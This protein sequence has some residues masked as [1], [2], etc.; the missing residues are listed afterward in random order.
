MN[1]VTMNGEIIYLKKRERKTNRGTVC[2]CVFVCVCFVC[3][4]MK[5]FLL[6]DVHG[7]M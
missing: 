4:L 5:K 6:L 2:M 3:V 1:T 7:I